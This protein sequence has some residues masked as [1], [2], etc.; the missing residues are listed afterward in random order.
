MT[1]WTELYA[2]RGMRVRYA[3]LSLLELCDQMPPDGVLGVAQIKRVV[4]TELRGADPAVDGELPARSSKLVERLLEAIDETE[5]IARVTAGGGGLPDPVW[6]T[7]PSRSGKW[8]ILREVDDNTPIGYISDGRWEIRHVTRHDP[9]AVLLRCQADRDLIAE[10]MSWEHVPDGYYSCPLFIDAAAGETVLPESR[11][12]RTCV[13]GL[14]SRR[15]RVLRLLAKGY[16]ITVEA[17][18]S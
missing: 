18:T 17:T 16:D 1:N 8:Q 15:N 13:C 7:E 5:D 3:L 11:A 10:V 14:D 12:G 4:K 9:A 2:A 6:I